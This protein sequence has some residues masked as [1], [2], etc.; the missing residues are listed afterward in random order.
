MRRKKLKLGAA[1]QRKQTLNLKLP[2]CLHKSMKLKAIVWGFKSIGVASP[3]CYMNWGPTWA[4]F[5]TCVYSFFFP[6]LW[7]YVLGNFI[8]ESLVTSEILM[9]I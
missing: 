3:L 7:L 5:S 8:I 2:K 6:R 4:G 1:S 9:Y